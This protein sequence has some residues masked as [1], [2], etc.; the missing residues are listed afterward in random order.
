MSK[1]DLTPPNGD[2]IQALFANNRAWAQQMELDNPG[3]F[4][5]L[6]DQQSPRYLW[7]G[8]A[9]SRVPANQITGL[10]PGEVFVHRNVANVVFE[11][12]LNCMAVLEFAIQV[13]QVRHVI[14]CGHYGCA[15]VRAARE[16]GTHGVVDSWLSGLRGLWNSHKHEFEGLDDAEAN[17]RF[18]ELNV[19]HQVATVARTSVVQRAWDEGRSLDIHG[20]IYG[21]EDGLLRD[22]GE[23]L[24]LPQ[25]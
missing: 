13:L 8:C 21:V 3:F 4:D 25:K 5:R 20:W 1:D 17:R 23:R 10:V 14:V 2:E 7:I 12:D 9:D 15:G 19:R 11:N 6:A 24:C 16:G 18:C 22:L